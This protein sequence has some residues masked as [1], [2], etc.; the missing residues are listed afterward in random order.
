MG[1]YLA[2][3]YRACAS[4]V[5]RCCSSWTLTS[6]YLATPTAS[7]MAVRPTERGDER[8]QRLVAVAART[9]F[10]VPVAGHGTMMGVEG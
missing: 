6:Q 3:S 2:E 10:S 1:W 4:S 9:W 7:R 5:R 8:R